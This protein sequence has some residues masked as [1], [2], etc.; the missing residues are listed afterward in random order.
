M[1]QPE[2]LA[3]YMRTRR[4]AGVAL[5]GWVVALSWTV[6]VSWWLGQQQPV[7]LLFGIPKWVVLGVALPWAGC[8]AFNCW[9][10]LVYQKEPAS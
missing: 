1:T 8:F 6:G 10:T 7:P 9:Y 5:V 4:E 3:N 2:R